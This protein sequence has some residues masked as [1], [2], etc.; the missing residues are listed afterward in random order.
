MPFAEEIRTIDP[1]LPASS[2]VGAAAMT[3]CHTPTRLMSIVVRNSSSVKSCQWLKMSMP[4]LATMPSRRPP[5]LG[6][7]GARD[8]L[9]AG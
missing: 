7:S 6:D 1:P 4:A 3:V 5:R 9:E 8:L 2:I